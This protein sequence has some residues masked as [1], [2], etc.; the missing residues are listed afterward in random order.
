MQFQEPGFLIFLILVLLIFLINLLGLFSFFPSR[1][2]GK[3]IKI[4]EKFSKA[5]LFWS[6]FSTGIISTI[7]ATPCTAPFVGTAVSFALSQNYLFTFLIFISMGIGKS[8]PYFIFIFK[9]NIIHYFP[10][11]GPWMN[12]IKYFFAGLL[13]LTI[14]WLGNITY[15]NL[16]KSYDNQINIE[17]DWEEF[18]KIKLENYINE[19]RLIFLD[20]TA[21][22]CVTCQVNK[23]TVLEDKD[24]L[25]L[26]K[27]NDIVLLRADWTFPSNEILD[28]LKSHNKYGIPFNI[29]YSKNHRS[30]YLFKELLFKEAFLEKM[31]DLIN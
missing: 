2:F 28:F 1:I 18:S 31:E 12:F 21:D 19:D 15:N 24:V 9:P 8:L 10:K 25:K 29:F 23:K 26:F 22:W 3:A 5:G 6:N 17:N 30:G 14:L 20:I 7:L 11:P 27:E 4:G 13:L 16:S